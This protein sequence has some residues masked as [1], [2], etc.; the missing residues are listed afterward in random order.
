MS[1]FFGAIFY[2]IGLT[3]DRYRIVKIVAL[4]VALGWGWKR[5]GNKF[6][7]SSL[8]F[9]LGIGVSAYFRQHSFFFNTGLVVVSKENYLIVQTLSGRYYVSA[10]SNPYEWLSIVRIQG[11]ISDYGF[12]FYESQMNFNLYLKENLVDRQIVAY[13]IEILASFPF[14]LRDWVRERWEVYPE[15]VCDFLSLFFLNAGGNE[16]LKTALYRNQLSYCLLLSSFH[17][18]FLYGIVRRVL[19]I[20]QSEKNAEKGAIFALFFFCFLSGW[21][22]SAFRLLIDRLIV[23]RSAYIVK[24]KIPPLERVGKTFLLMGLVVPNTMTS[25]YFLYSFPL[26]CFYSVLRESLLQI[27]KRKRKFYSMLLMQLFLIPIQFFVNE[28]G[29]PFSF[30]FGIFVGPF[31]YTLVLLFPFSLFPFVN[32]LVSFLVRLI[33]RALTLFDS[34][35]LVLYASYAWPLLLLIDALL[36]YSVYL[37]Y[38]GRSRK[39]FSSICAIGIIASIPLIPVENGYEKSISFINVGQG[40]SILIKDRNQNILV[41]TGG[42]LGNDLAVRTLIPY[43]RRRHVRQIDCLFLTHGD[44]DHSGAS[45]SLTAHFR[46]NE[47]CRENDFTA[48]D[49]PHFSIVNLNRYTDLWEDE[50]ARSMVLY[51][52]FFNYGF[53]LMGDAPKKI[54]RAIVKDYSGLKVDYLKVGHHGSNTSTDEALIACYHPREAIVS[55]GLKNRYDHPAEETIRIL[56][57]YGVRIRRTD[58]EGTI[59]YSFR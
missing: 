39:I 19:G 54:E 53:L 14:P 48:K 32:P 40:D 35:N 57:A 25:S 8:F 5:G 36:F 30:L 52:D 9:L 37:I 4:F 44:Y 42:A 41:D 12:T 47:I 1:S 29:C 27:E 15:E 24:K 21:K 58:R 55:V 10:Y 34:I 18:S 20:R 17:L 45:A 13:E 46:V 50:N 56:Q 3:F 51:L 6:W 22:Q 31:L 49:F 33:L 16:D 28:K 43:F 7:F 2:F 59:V 26:L 38:T 11:T 23:Y